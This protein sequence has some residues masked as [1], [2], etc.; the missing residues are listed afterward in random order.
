MRRPGVIALV[1]VVVLLLGVLTALYLKFTQTTASNSQLRA[2]REEVQAQYGEALTAIAEIQDSLSTL[3]VGEANS[4]LLPGSPRAEASLAGARSREAL[5]RIALLKAGI[6]RTKAR[7]RDLEG[8][9]SRSGIKVKGLEQLVGNLRATLQQK[10]SLVA[11]LTGQVDS[12]Q[13][14]VTGLSTEVHENQE[15]I[16]TQ[17][18][19]IEDK[20][21][22]L[23]TV[24]Y[25][26]G[27]QHQLVTWGV[28]ARRGGLLGLGRTLTVTGYDRDSLFTALDTDHESVI[29]VPSGS[30]KVLSAQ[31]PASYELRTTGAQTEL[32]ILDPKSF[33][34]VRYLVILRG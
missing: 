13:T 6:Q 20:R 29:Q 15:T 32:H 4:P 21:R 7:L 3:G 33:R 24:Y 22:E 12:L 1:A 18:V 25:V 14:Q 11:Q 16:R 26:I 9:L 17:A 34:K 5:D 10:E 19:N 27:T 2:A 28:V 23:G 31:S 8:S 30:A